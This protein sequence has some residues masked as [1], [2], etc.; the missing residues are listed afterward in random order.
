MPELLSK[1]F[2]Q[3]SFGERVAMNAPIQ[4][5]AADIMKIAM[6]RVS[7]RLR[8]ENLESKLLVQVH[9]ELLIEAKVEETQQVCNL[10]TEEMAAAAE[11]SVE[12]L[13]DAHEGKNWYEAK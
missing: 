7:E 2:M 8:K 4:G 11:L 3:R 12:L 9:D 5:T 1:N 13:V 10:L 6:I